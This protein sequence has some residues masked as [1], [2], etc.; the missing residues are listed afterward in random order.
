VLAADERQR[1]AEQ[2]R[3]GDPNDELVLG[4]NDTVTPIR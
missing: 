1:D 2:Q 3:Q 4:T